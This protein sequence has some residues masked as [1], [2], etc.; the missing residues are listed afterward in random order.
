MNSFSP[1]SIRYPKGPLAMSIVYS[2]TIAAIFASIIFS[3][4]LFLSIDDDP[5]MMFMFGALA[6]IFELGKFFTWYEFGERRA[7]HNYSGAFT[8][9]VFYTVLALISIA[10]SIGGINSAANAAQE[11]VAVKQNKIAA[12]DRQIEAIEKQI[13]LNNI[14]AQKYIEME[15]ITYGVKRIQDENTLLRQQQLDLANQRD[16]LP[17]ENNGSSIALIDSLAGGLNISV[18]TAQF[19]IVVFLSVLLDLFAA[20]FVGLIGE[21]LRFKKSYQE[22][23]RFPV[24]ESEQFVEKEQP[25]LILPQVSEAESVEVFD[26]PKAEEKQLDSTLIVE[27]NDT[28]QAPINQ[29]SADMQADDLAAMR[30]SYRQQILLKAVAVF[31]EGSI[32]CSKP[33]L[34]QVL[35]LSR[36][37]ADF[38]FSD[39]LAQGLVI[40]KAN[41]HFSWKGPLVAQSDE[42]A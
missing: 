32:R 42:P 21:E 10:G 28:Q 36:E 22:R 40:Q 5:V 1:M 39:L 20:F 18:V 33:A 27:P 11:H 31:S 13:Q 16:S 3:L 37:E 9:L 29:D 25:L 14:A 4:L 30:Q 17:I 6:I 15:R 35:S 23:Q 34:M 24:I 41:K 2:F 38:V 7:R 12:F 8:A 19:S 26:E